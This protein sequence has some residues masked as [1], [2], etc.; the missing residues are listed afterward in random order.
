MSR[1]LYWAPKL[2]YQPSPDPEYARTRQT[3]TFLADVFELQGMNCYRNVEVKQ[4]KITFVLKSTLTCKSLLLLC[5]CTVLFL[6]VNVVNTTVLFNHCVVMQV[7]FSAFFKFFMRS[8]GASCINFTSD[9]A[10]SLTTATQVYFL[11]FN[12]RR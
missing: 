10:A 8:F 3:K 5:L 9:V 6:A 11:L 2:K 7:L 1:L 12:T 4:L